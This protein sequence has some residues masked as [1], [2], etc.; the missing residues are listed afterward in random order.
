MARSAPDF[1]YGRDWSCVSEEEHATTVHFLTFLFCS[2]ILTL[3][4][5]NY[6]P[7]KN[8]GVKGAQE[9][10]ARLGVVASILRSEEGRERSVYRIY[11]FAKVDTL[12]M[13]I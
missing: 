13:K 1:L 2:T 8:P 4:P 10:F 12:L 11:S 9:R 5:L 7:D 3:A 6:S